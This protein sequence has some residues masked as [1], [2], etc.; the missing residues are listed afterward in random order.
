[1]IKEALRKA[2]NGEDLSEQEMG[3]C[4]Q[5]ILGGSATKAQIGALMTALRIKGET[6]DEIAAAARVIRDHGDKVRLSNHLVNVDRDEINVEDETVIQRP[7]EELDEQ[8]DIPGIAVTIQAG[9]FTEEKKDLALS[10]AMQKAEALLKRGLIFG[11]YIVVD[12]KVV[13]TDFVRQR[14]SKQS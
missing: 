6:V 12:E 14:L 8:T 7:A 2:V 3:G 11:A 10:G 1:M 4:M 13:M 9:P 5:Q